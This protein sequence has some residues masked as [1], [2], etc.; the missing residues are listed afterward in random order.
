[1]VGRRPRLRLPVYILLLARWPRKGY[2]GARRAEP[3]TRLRS[4]S[5]WRF[6]GLTA[7]PNRREDIFFG[8]RI[9]E[10]PLFFLQQEMGWTRR[11][12][13]SSMHRGFQL[14]IKDTLLF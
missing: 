8:T 5:E 13:A 12:R 9:S 4:R 6:G 10:Y 14:A 2:L 7:R 11:H 1:M 3:G